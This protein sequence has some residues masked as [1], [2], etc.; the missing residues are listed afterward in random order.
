MGLE[1]AFEAAWT[2]EK[3][4]SGPLGQLTD[5]FCEWLRSR[6]FCRNSIRRH[7]GR[8]QHLN[9]YLGEEE[10]S[11]R[12]QLTAR[13]VEGFWK[14]RAKRCRN[15]GVGKEHLRGVGYSI[16]RLTEYLQEERR[17]EDC[18]DPPIYQPLLD[19]YLQWMRDQQQAAAGTLRIRRHGIQTFLVQLGAPATLE[20]LSDLHAEQIERFVLAYAQHKGRAARRS[21]QSALRTFLRFCLQRGYLRHPLEDAVPTLR[22]YRL[23][24]LP[25]GVSE[26][27]VQRVLEAIDRG[28]PAGLRDFAI[29]QILHS[30]GVRG[31]QVRALRL[32]DIQ[33]EKDRI[34]F[35]ALKNGKH[36]LLPLTLAVGESLLDHLHNGR[37]SCA[38]R[39]VFL[40]CRAPLGPLRHS[41]SLSEIVARR[42]RGAHAFRHA[43]ATRMLAQGHSLKA[44]ADV[45][46]HR[47]LS[48]TF[49]YTKVD[50][51]ALQAVALE[52]PR[53][54]AS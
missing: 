2:L 1:E 52:W 30:Y 10:D 17:W 13:D 8:I 9:E 20:G 47:H 24:G 11:P 48:T 50:F 51:Q 5:G 39:E 42:F 54:E 44:L 19:E 16:H 33:W 46:G 28:T 53:E 23:S 35:R 31:G 6:G 38:F 34:L 43:F 3:L 37:P 15:R 32:Q 21:L 26:S 36:S 40:T 4:R 18:M 49:Q 41:T 45:L 29:L 12:L 14:S 7:L 22:T 27:E 25:A